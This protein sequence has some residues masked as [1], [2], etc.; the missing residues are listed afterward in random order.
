MPEEH[1]ILSII[2]IVFGWLALKAILTAIFGAERMGV[3]SRFSRHGKTTNDNS[4]VK[5]LTQ[6]VAMLTDR[7]KVLERIT[8]EDG[9][10]LA[11]EIDRL[12]APDKLG[13]GGVDEL[14]DPSRSRNRI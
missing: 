13:Y 14:A 2:G 9:N 1:F 7:V 4:E 5:A 6:Q 3:R 10:T 8:V 11:A 12:R